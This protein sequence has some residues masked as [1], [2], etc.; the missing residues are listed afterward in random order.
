MVEQILMEFSKKE[1]AVIDRLRT[2]RQVQEY[3]RSLPYNWK[4]T[5]RTFRNVVEHGEANCIEA[6]LAAATIM[7]QH[8]YP[9]LLLDLESI[10]LLDHVLFLYQIRG[11]WGSIGKSR[12]AGLHGRKPVFKTVR[13]LVLSYVEPYVDGTGRICGYGVAD[14]NKLTKANWRLSER[15]VWTIEKAL[16]ARPR[17]IL[18]TSDVRYKVMLRRFRQFKK[19]NPDRPFP[20]KDVLG[21]WL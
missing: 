3:L 11:R 4:N 20:Y 14:L 12:D 5:L 19:Q 13:H 2:P 17:K 10:D 21:Q 15:N 1:Q 16:I 6:A 18:R 9:P 7:E 8:G